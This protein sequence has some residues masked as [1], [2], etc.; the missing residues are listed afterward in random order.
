MPENKAMRKRP[1][2]SEEQLSKIIEHL[3]YEFQMLN[4]TAVV[5]ATLPPILLH[6]SIKNALMESFTVH[7]RNLLGFLWDL[8][9]WDDDVIASDFF[10]DQS[11]WDD[12][13]PT[14]PPILEPLDGRVGKEVAHLTY[15]RIGI[16][17]EDKQWHFLEMAKAL[18]GCF[19]EFISRAPKARLGELSKLK[20]SA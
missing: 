13:P 9:P 20:P 18:N 7:A 11:T 14:I 12:N 10:D 6:E 4:H 5:L 8:T 2:R 3:G 17:P 19:F 15:A 1:R 16:S